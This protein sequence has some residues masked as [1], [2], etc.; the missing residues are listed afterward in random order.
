MLEKQ[1][2]G[3]SQHVLKILGLDIENCDIGEDFLKTKNTPKFQK[4][5]Y[6][7]LHGIEAGRVSTPV[8]RRTAIYYLLNFL[9]FKNFTSTRV[10][11][12]KS[13]SAVVTNFDSSFYFQHS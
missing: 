2:A 4:R 1:R 13:L 10:F 3:Q 12:I 5:M 11:S 8:Q 9:F 6:E 7:N